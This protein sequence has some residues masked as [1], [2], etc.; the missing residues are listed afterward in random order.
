MIIKQQLKALCD[1]ILADYPLYN[2]GYYDVFKPSQKDVVI[3]DVG[4]YCGIADNNGNY[5]Y[6]RQL[7]EAR[8]S[9]QKYSCR[10]IN[11]Q[12]T[13][14]CRIVSVIRTSD[15]QAH[16]D[17]LIYSLTKQGHVLSRAVYEPTSVFR[18]ETG[19]TNMSLSLDD[20]SLVLADFTISYNESAKYCPPQICNC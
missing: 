1:Q 16:L 12:V 7:R 13:I 18:E 2:A 11:Y 3:N 15:Y 5:F 6:I 10:P 19:T 4:D 8:Y 20:L 14:Q 9:P 17:A